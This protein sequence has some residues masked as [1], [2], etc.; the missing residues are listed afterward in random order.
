MTRPS[1]FVPFLV[2][3]ALSATL[4]AAPQTDDPFRAL[5]FRSIGP[6]L[7]GGRVDDVAVVESDPLT[8]Y[9][10]TASG[11]IWKTVNAGTTFAPV[12][13]RYETSSIGDVTV[14]PSNPSVVWAGTGEPNNRQS[15]SWGHGVYRSL[16][17]GATWQHLGLEGTL[18][19]GRIVVHPRDEHTAWV[20]A[21]GS[22]WGPGRE[23]GL[24][25]TTDGGKSWVNTKFVD[26][27]TG[28]VDVAVDPDSPNILYAASYQRR[29]TPFGFS[30]GG[31]GSGIWRTTDGGATWTRLA[32]G[33]PEQGD[34]GRIGLAVFR[35]DPR[36]VFATVEHATEGGVYRSADRGESWTKVSSTN[37]RPSYYS[38]IHV[39]PSNE[40]RIW[41]LG[42][43][44][45]FSEDGGKTFKTDRI[46]KIHGDY[47]ALWID[48]ANSDH[49]LIGSDGGIHVSWDG[50][51]SMDFINTVA[52]A[53]FYEVAY[54]MRTPYTVCGGLQDNGSWCGPSRTAHDQGIANEDWFRVGGGDGFFTVI[55]PVDPDTIYVESQD[56]NV[57]RFDRRT[58]E[59]RVIRPEPPAGEKYRFN[60]NS[61]IVLSP[62]D[63][64]T[65]YY[66][67]NRL[68]GSSDRGDTWTLVTPDLTG[69]QAR[70]ELPIFG[71]TSKEFLSR[72]DGVVHWGTITAIAESPVQRGVLWVGTDDGNLQLSRDGGASWTN[73]SAKVKGVPKGTYV[74]RIE[75]SR[76]GASTAYVAF[77]G[78]RGDDF[79]PYLFRTSDFGQT[80]Q[81]LSAGLPPAGTVS[82]MRE[83]P[84]KTDVLL[85]GT[86]RGLF[87]SWDR[88]AGWSR[89]RA[90]LPTMPV[91]DIQVHPRDNDLILA[92][93]GRGIWI[94]D[95][96]MPLLAPPAV[97]A[98]VEVLPIR[99]AAQL[100]IY[101]HKANTGH[102]AFLGPNPPDGALIT[103][104]LKA[105]PA[106]KERVKITVTD[107]AGAVVRA[108]E[109]PGKAG[110][111]RTN[112]DLR[113]EP[114]VPPDP[115]ATS[116]FGRSRGPLVMPGPYTV[117]VAVGEASAQQ[118]VEVREDPR[119]VVGAE[120]RAAW[121]AACRD[122]AALFSRADAANKRTT[123]LKKQLEEQ[124]ATLGKD[125]KAS[126]E[127]RTAVG[128]LLDRVTELGKKLTRSRPMG[129]AGA[130]L[131]DEPD[132][133][134]G[135]TRGLYSALSS[136]TAAPTPQ[137]R[138]LVTRL[139]SEV[140]EVVKTVNALI[141]TEAPALNKQMFEAGY[142]RLDPGKPVD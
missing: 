54:D 16:D 83:H 29:R 27:D 13:D 64:K 114:P 84:S 49:L 18:H 101:S 77:D 133:L 128:D 32:K 60:W 97:T 86:E 6:A 46:E 125:D 69:A 105:A 119:V 50:G 115:E 19:V 17:G 110:L 104:A 28:F 39:D 121:T 42:A 25:R 82:V 90:N 51:R 129:F 137:Q 136:M 89:V 40:L 12:F 63:P 132:P 22:L 58:N 124:K 71:K 72:N 4:V 9:V 34:L 131:A 31:P 94:L 3:L 36:I 91:D 88:G 57:Q 37:P 23:R 30:G 75:A 33:L 44:M 41:V 45:Y 70:D 76:T 87:V 21:L 1:R 140:D 10:A 74:S 103:Y 107:A 118:S 80:W 112:W 78:H 61:P 55:D 98:P 108:L 43:Q 47:H 113:Y 142:G 127:L 20:A 122:A 48:P 93:H 56:G 62:H 73:L 135:R 5:E 7:M 95:D 65:V 68:F 11:G 81:S 85:A 111:N 79:T 92:S 138:D 35:R 53:Q 116:F 66:G 130:S 141:E 99:P 2:C 15:S 96:M 38:K 134:V 67:G 139:T 8:Y 117:K 59:R 52:L 123:A 100:R 24:Y 109:E 126:P 120:E 14:S 102:K 106:E 26:E